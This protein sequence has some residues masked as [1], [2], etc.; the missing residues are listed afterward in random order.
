MRTP[1]W[2]AV[3]IAAL[4]ASCAPGI[5]V[6][7]L[8]VLA[9]EPEWGALARELG[10]DRVE[11]ADATTALQDP[12]HVQARPGLIARARNADLLVCTGADLEAGWLPVLLRQSGNP[13]IQPGA[14]GHFMA[15]GQ[16]TMLQVPA[17]V[18]RSHGDV[19]AEGNPHLHLDP[20]N[21]ARV[22]T[23]LARRF[24]EMD[25]EGRDAYAQRLADFGAR[26]E[27]ATAR[28]RTKAAALKGVTVVVQHDSWPYLSAWTGLRVAQTLEPKPGVE[29]S[30]SYLQSVLVGLKQQPARMIL[31]AAYQ[32][33]RASQWLA[34]RSGLPVVTLPFTVGGSP[35]A[36]DLFGLFDDTLDRMLQVLR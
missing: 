5:A 2:R 26:W 8:K 17:S 1:R 21:L 14:A 22:A 11:V 7:A 34:G 15:A 18:D 31:V 36:R 16:V 13:R 4:V 24:S 33:P 27:T 19:H 23:A 25:P 9:C 12:H 35:A 20:G 3:A 28:W 10:A 29:P 32:D 6:A 30:V